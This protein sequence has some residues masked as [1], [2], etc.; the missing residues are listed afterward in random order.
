MSEKMKA[1]FLVKN[2]AASKA[3]DYR[4]TEVPKIS[5]HEVLVKVEAFGL[6]FADVMCRLGLYPECPPLPTVIGYEVVGRVTAIGKD[7]DNLKVG[8]R[9]VGLTRFGGYAEYA[10]GDHRG[11][12]AIPEE[13]DAATATCFATQYSTAWYSAK[14]LINLRPEDVVL[15][16][17]AAGGVGSALVQIAKRTGCKVFGTAGSDE[18]LEFLKELGVDHP[19]NYRKNDF[20]VEVKK[21]MKKERIDVIFDPIGGK[22]IK[23]GLNLL[24]P[25]GKIVCF[26]ASALAGKKGIIG[27]LR[28]YLQFGIYHPTYFM[29]R[30]KSIL[31][32][33]ILKLGD[34]RPNTISRTLNDVIKE[35]SAGF[36]KPQKVTTY[37][38]SELA[39]AHEALEKRKTS[40]KVAILM[41]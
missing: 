28:V 37:K 2:G 18:K 17:A 24:G 16:H 4:E 8:D 33:N 32:V 6:N 19:I 26:G 38:F 36:L 13:W 25:G 27:K 15:V 23:K 9:T 22:S 12:A 1:A 29:M 35:A 3:F 21:I 7:V 40:G 31:G 30:S 39:E 5:D 14:E 10:K 41:G 11:F 34:Y 20:A